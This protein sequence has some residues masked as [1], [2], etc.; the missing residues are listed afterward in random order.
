MSLFAVCPFNKWLENLV[1]EDSP[2]KLHCSE[3]GD[4]KSTTSNEE[5]DRQVHQSAFKP[6]SEYTWK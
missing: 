2:L 1:G 5:E 4:L 3:K 6:K